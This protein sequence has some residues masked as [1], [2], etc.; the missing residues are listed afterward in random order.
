MKDD[1]NCQVL[2]RIV[3]PASEELLKTFSHANNAKLS[4]AVGLWV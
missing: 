2:R 1:E 4:T 3:A